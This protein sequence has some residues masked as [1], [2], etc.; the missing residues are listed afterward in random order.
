MFPLVVRYNQLLYMP[1]DA[2]LLAMLLHQWS[3]GQ[4]SVCPAR[5]LLSH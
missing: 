5:D 2:E 3:I 1:D 4:W